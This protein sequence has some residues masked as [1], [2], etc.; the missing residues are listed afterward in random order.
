MRKEPIQP[1]R[2][3]KSQ[4]GVDP[5]LVK[6]R[7]AELPGM[8]S[9]LMTDL[10]PNLPKT[11]YPGKEGVAAIRNETEAA[12]AK[13]DMSHIKSG[14]TVNIWVGSLMRK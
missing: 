11:I 5:A 6:K 12:L 4:Y 8:V 2:L 7:G 13:V 10:F 1:A 14:Q 9:I 3:R